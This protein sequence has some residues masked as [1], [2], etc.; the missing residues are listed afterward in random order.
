MGLIN[1]GSGVQIT[2]ASD[3]EVFTGYVAAKRIYGEELKPGAKR[4]TK[5]LRYAEGDPVPADEATVLGK[6]VRRVSVSGKAIHDAQDKAIHTAEAKRK[7][8]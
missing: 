5:F 6:A 3:D 4:P 2:H 1:S 8:V 7:V